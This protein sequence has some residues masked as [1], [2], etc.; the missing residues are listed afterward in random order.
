[1]THGLCVSAQTTACAT[2]TITPNQSPERM[3]N[4]ISGAEISRINRLSTARSRT[5]LVIAMS[6][7][8]M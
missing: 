8:S 7:T 4:R 1:M 3:M 2:P 5:R 6:R